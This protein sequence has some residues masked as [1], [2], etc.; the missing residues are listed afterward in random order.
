MRKQITYSLSLPQEIKMVPTSPLIKPIVSV[1]DSCMS[2]VVQF[3]FRTASALYKLDISMER[4][5]GRP[6]FTPEVQSKSDVKDESSQ[7]S[8]VREKL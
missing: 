4:A 6:L 2:A 8:I 7:S 5:G 3:P 1:L